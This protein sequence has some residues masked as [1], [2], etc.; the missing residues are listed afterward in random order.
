MNIDSKD[1]EPL[2]LVLKTQNTYIL[3]LLKSQIY[4]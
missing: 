3:L 1:L 4:Q 2:I